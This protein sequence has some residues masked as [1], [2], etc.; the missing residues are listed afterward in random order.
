[1]RGAVMT[2]R[3]ADLVVADEDLRPVRVMRRGEWLS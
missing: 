3:A 2:G 1:V